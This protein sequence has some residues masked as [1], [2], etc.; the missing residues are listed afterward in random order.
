MGRGFQWLDGSFVEDKVP[1][2]LDIV[3][4]FEAPTA[5]A[6]NPAAF[7]AARTDL[8]HRAAARSN[9]KLDVQWVDMSRG[10]RS[11]VEFTQYYCGLFS[12]RR[13]DELWKGMLAVDLDDPTE[14]A[15]DQ[16]LALLASTSPG[17]GP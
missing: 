1:N 16:S 11:I 17:V 15:A 6:Q 10:G 12:H 4:F 8:F 7:V 2:D 13:G 5:Y 14:A 9:Y 3:T